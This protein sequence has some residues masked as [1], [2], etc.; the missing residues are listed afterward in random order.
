MQT[1]LK[2]T[3]LALILSCISCKTTKP[4]TV[5]S[6]TKYLSNPHDG[7]VTI[8]AVGQGKK[9]DEARKDAFRTGFT[10]LLFRGLPGFSPLKN[11][12]I[13]NEAKALSSHRSF[14]D[15]FFSDQNY[16]QFVTKQDPTRFSGDRSNKIA[17]QT[18]S[19]NYKLLRKHLEQ[20]NIIRK[21][22]L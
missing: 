18:F 2:M 12:L 16:I 14:F 1:I 9:E 21:F 4:A 5:S 7:V 11:P 15:D 19:V 17:H 8:T 20:N 6:E 13:S 10:T 22:G 3:M